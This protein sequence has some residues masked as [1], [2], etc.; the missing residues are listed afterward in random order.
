MK[1]LQHKIETTGTMTFGLQNSTFWERLKAVT[2]LLFR[3][4]ALMPG[5]HWTIEIHGEEPVKVTTP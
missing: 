5:N 1:T 2:V 4:S 3:R